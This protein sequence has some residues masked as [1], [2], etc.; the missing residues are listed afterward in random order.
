MRCYKT[1]I[2]IGGQQLGLQRACDWRPADSP[3]IG[4]S[5]LCWVLRESQAARSGARSPVNRQPEAALDDNLWQRL[6]LPV[7]T[8]VYVRQQRVQVLSARGHT[9]W[10]RFQEQ[11]HKHGFPAANRAPQVHALHV[12]RARAAGFTRRRCGCAAGGRG[13]RAAAFGGAG[14]RRERALQQLQRLGRRQLAGI[15]LQAAL[16]DEAA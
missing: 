4:K 8:L 11:I 2:G 9:R 6:L 15:R 3:V 5:D 13:R 10:Q 7:R 12:T 1:V 16:A 14:A